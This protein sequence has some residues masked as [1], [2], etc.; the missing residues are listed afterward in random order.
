MMGSFITRGVIMALGYV[1]P[2]YE[3]YKI[4]ERKRPDVE[5]LRFWCQYWIIIAVVTVLERLADI[6]ISW[7][8][9]YSEAKLAF[10]IYL[11]YPKTMGT[12]YVYTTLLRPLLVQHE[13][14]IDQNLNELR[15]RAGD[16]ALLWWQRGSIYLQARFYELLQFLAS[17]PNRAPQGYPRGPARPPNQG[18]PRGLPQGGSSMYPP[19]PS[20]G[21]PPDVAYPPPGE[22]GHHGAVPYPA[23][24]GAQGGQG[25]YPPLPSYSSGPYPRRP[26]GRS[27][28]DEDGDLDYDV[29]DDESEKRT[30]F[31]SQ[32]RLER[33]GPSAG[34]QDLPPRAQNS[35]IRQRD[36][37]PWNLSV[38]L[39]SW[40]GTAQSDKVD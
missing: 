12:T 23:S 11:W 27:L 35:R 24:Q 21:F 3:C 33:S 2:A 10:I 37:S 5:H 40:L 8:P 17:Q 20:A 9:L 16:V 34:E 19:P 1:Y 6:L 36:D 28:S 32:D 7:V 31:R 39:P 18:P 30:R 26:Y 4:V 38:W 14:D 25:L 29:V 13:S 22:G 15:A